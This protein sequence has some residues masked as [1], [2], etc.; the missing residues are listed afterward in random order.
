[1]PTAT[2]TKLPNAGL[3][4]KAELAK[5]APTKGS[6]KPKIDRLHSKAVAPKV[7]K[8]AINSVKAPLEK[9]SS[10]DD[11][12]SFDEDG[13]VELDYEDMDKSDLKPEQVQ[14]HGVHPDRVKAAGNGAGPN[15]SVISSV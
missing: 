13:G 8:P 2:K 5:E 11:F 9:D 6:K 10:G 14:F 15:G 7:I 1:M 4:R 12:S 3:K